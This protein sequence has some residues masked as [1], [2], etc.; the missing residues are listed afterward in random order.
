MKCLSL[1][2]P[3]GWLLLTIK[4]V[5][6]R[7]WHSDFRGPCLIHHSKTWDEGCSDA[8][9]RLAPDFRF[10]HTP[11]YGCIIG[12]VIITDCVFRFPDENA[13]LYSKWHFP[14]QYAYVRKD[15]VIFKTPIPYRGRLGF[16]DVPDDAVREALCQT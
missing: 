13:N 7:R 15:P 11:D 1:K 2:P 12:K 3:W 16:F 9:L 14:G 4:D 8:I 6:N 5:E 10:D